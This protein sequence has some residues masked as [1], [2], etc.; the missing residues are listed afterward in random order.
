LLACA[1]AAAQTGEPP[2]ARQV[3][4]DPAFEARA[5]ALVGIL[6]GTG[7]YAG[8]FTPAFQAAVPKEKFAPIN[9]Q[10]IAA[11]G[12]PVAVDGFALDTPYSGVVRIRYEKATLAFLVVVDPAA[13]HQVSG[14]RV[15]GAV[16]QEKTLGEVTGALQKL[17]G[18][19]GYAFAR[20]GAGAPAINL[21]HHAD[22]PLAVGS[23]FKL[24]ILAELVRAT[25]AGERN[26][27][28]LVTLDGGQLPGGGYA[29]KPAGTKVSLRELATQ[30]ISISD[31]S[32]TDILLAT[33]GRDKVEAM[34]PALGV[35]PDPRNIPYLGTLEAFKLKWLEGGKLGDRYNA[36]DDAGQRAMLAGEIRTADMAPLLAI[37]TAPRVPSRIDRL[38]WFFAPADQIRVMDWLRRNTEGA[39][40]ADARAILSKNPGIAIDKAQYD[41]AGF[42]G[43]SEPGVINLTLLLRGTDGNWYAAAASWNDT[44]QPVDEARFVGLMATLVKLAGPQK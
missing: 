23:A 22:K 10:L 30:M 43:G 26:W 8:F 24:A 9:V 42:K 1:P 13:P 36:L 33:L 16:A 15:N 29:F 28:D 7:D 17:P 6:A 21:Q 5:S 37:R 31:N 35:R 39:G 25:N 2:A 4:A 40:G 18:M 3:R 20:L 32:A 38:E 44:A 34:L 12:A 19:T 11:Y 41:W 14:L 27:D